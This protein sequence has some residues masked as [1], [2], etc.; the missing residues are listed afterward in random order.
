MEAEPFH[1]TNPHVE[2]APLEE[3]NPARGGG[4]Y[5]PAERRRTTPTRLGLQH[6]AQFNF[7]RHFLRGLR[8]FV[9]LLTAD[10]ASFYVMRELVRAVRDHAVLGPTIAAQVQRWLPAGILNG[11]QYA[12]AL[13][14]GLLVL[15]NYGPGDQRSEER[16]V[17]KECRS[18]WSP[19]H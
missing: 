5:A 15:G 9:I 4:A 11:W 17:G 12:A 8:R 14:V 3:P 10:L 2:S 7:R 1:I 19:Y 13:F 16:R 6:R 18:R